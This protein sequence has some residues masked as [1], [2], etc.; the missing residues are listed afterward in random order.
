M[1]LILCFFDELFQ[2]PDDDALR[3]FLFLLAFSTSTPVKSFHDELNRIKKRS[4][5]DLKLAEIRSSIPNNQYADN[6]LHEK[7]I[8]TKTYERESFNAR[9]TSLA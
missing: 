7:D 6:S 8:K 9:Y 3:T 5:L 2:F 4:G 1:Q